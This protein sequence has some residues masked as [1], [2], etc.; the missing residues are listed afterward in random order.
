MNALI[1]ESLYGQRFC[2]E[3]FRTPRQDVSTLVLLYPTWAGITDFERSVARQ[4]NGEG[5]DAMIIDYHGKG[6]DLSSL[7]GRQQ[8]M[9]SLTNDFSRLRLL[10][11]ELTDGAL[12]HTGHYAHLAS[13]G[14]CLGGTCSLQ[15]GLFD[16]RVSAAISFHG[17]LSFPK[18][19]PVARQE[20]RFLILNGALD[21]MVSDADISA[22]QCYFDEYSLDMTFMNF[23]RTMHSFAI[24]GS[25]NPANGVRYNSATDKRS[26]QYALTCLEELESVSA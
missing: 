4:L 24:P 2:H 8:A 25:D 7:E 14:Y 21:P 13:I 22:T 10:L 11:A 5:F 15:A 1:E 19:T 9:R 20:C 6:V 16:Q 12:T 18:D 26:W 3:L 17:L 23:S